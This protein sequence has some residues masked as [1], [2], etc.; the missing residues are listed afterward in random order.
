VS[1]IRGINIR[2]LWFHYPLG[3]REWFGKR[4]KYGG[5]YIFGERYNNL[6][7]WIEWDLYGR[8][9]KWLWELWFKLFEI[10]SQQESFLRK[11]Q[12]TFV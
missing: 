5:G 4:T 8:K 9:G 2:I 3:R 12:E 1:F 7:Y 10:T 11:S 6:H